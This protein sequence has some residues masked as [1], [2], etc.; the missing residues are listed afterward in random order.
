MCSEDNSGSGR[1]VADCEL[2][3]EGAENNA[4]GLH[5][6]TNVSKFNIPNHACKYYSR[7]FHSIS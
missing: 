3:S 5:G 1:V 2:A 4:S 6:S 7:I